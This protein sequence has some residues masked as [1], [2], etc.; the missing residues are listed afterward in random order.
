MLLLDSLCRHWRAED[1][2]AARLACL[3]CKSRR[4]LCSA[5]LRSS[6]QR[7]IYL[8]FFHAATFDVHRSHDNVTTLGL[9]VHLR[10]EK[11]RPLHPMN[12]TSRM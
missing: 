5:T 2:H 7:R 10:F 3:P 1:E 11:G 9:P 8:E 12:G 4:V 6:M